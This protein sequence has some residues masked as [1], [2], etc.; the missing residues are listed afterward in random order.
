MQPS[1]SS[2]SEPSPQKKRRK[3]SINEES[4]GSD[5]D[6]KT[7]QCNSVPSTQPEQCLDGNPTLVNKSLWPEITSWLN[8][9]QKVLLKF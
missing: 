5:E 1:S 4:G 8:S 7:M 2:S 3:V 6:K 9:E